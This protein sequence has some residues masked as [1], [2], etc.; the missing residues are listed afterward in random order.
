M[1]F[2]SILNWEMESAIGRMPSLMI[3]PQIVAQSNRSEFDCNEEAEPNPPLEVEVPYI[4][5]SEAQAKRL[6]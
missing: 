1:G 5:Q 2:V 6:S 4:K 3:R